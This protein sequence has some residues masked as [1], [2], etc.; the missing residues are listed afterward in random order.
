MTEILAT[1]WGS[2]TD[3]NAVQMSVRAVVV[4]ALVLFMFRISGRRSLSQH[5]PFD[6]C[7]TVLLGAIL[8]R[9]VVGASPFLPTIASGAALVLLHRAVAMLSVR[10]RRFDVLVN[11]SPRTLL[12]NGKPDPVAMRKGLVSEADLMQA[13]REHGSLEALDQIRRIELERDGTITV[14][15]HHGCAQK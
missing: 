12:L 6:A 3:L 1:L 15:R 4:F 2:G 5:S 10:F 13:V 8:S 14:N 7:I 11:G 9:C